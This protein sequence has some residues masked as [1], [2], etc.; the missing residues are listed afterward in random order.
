MKPPVA[1]LI[2]LS[3]RPWVRTLALVVLIGATVFLLWR[4]DAPPAPSAT[5]DELRGPAEPDGFVVDGHYRAYDAQGNLH[6]EFTSPRIEQFE[7]GNVA[8]MDSPLA[9]VYGDEG[10]TP[11]TV[12]A[13]HGSLLQNERLLYLTG[14]VRVTRTAAGQDTRLTTSELTLDSDQGVAYT[15]APVEISDRYGTT[16]ATGMKAWIDQR[17]LELNAHVE[18]R[19]DTTP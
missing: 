4:S 14:D 15:D 8:T 7:A 12:A 19:Y 9:H 6:I 1:S 10:N 17:I 13:D 18:G 16:R 3:E 2:D 11:W 5:P